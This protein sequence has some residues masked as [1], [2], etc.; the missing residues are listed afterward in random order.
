MGFR[1]AIRGLPL[2]LACV[3]SASAALAERREIPFPIPNGLFSGHPLAVA[4]RSDGRIG[5]ALVANIQELSGHL[6]SFSVSEAK[7]ID[8]FDLTADF[9]ALN[10][11]ISPGFS[12]RVHEETGLVAVYGTTSNR[13][14]KVVTLS[15]D[16]SGHLFKRWQAVYL[17][18]N[19]LWPELAFNRDGSRVCVV[20]TDKD[21]GSQSR[22][23]NDGESSQ[24]GTGG[25]AFIETVQRADLIRVEDGAVLATASLREAGDFVW[26]IFDDAHNRFIALLERRRTYL[27]TTRMT[28]E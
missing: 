19:G 21:S 23:A 3:L 10:N 2:M 24:T 11:G 1:V 27:Q 28:C 13:V 20:Y 16:A 12:L 4:V 14:Q 18:A 17:P 15:S 6:F 7:V 5:F 25:M 26:A 22:N 8:E 9:G